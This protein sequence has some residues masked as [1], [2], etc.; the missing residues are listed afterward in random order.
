[1][2]NT[3]KLIEEILKG[4]QEYITDGYSMSIGEIVSNYKEGEIDINPDF[5]RKFRWTDH[6]RSRLIESILIGVPLPSIFVY[7]NDKGI[8][9]VVDGVQRLSTILEFMGELKDKDGNKIPQS[10]LVRTKMLPSIEGLK[11]SDFPKEPLQIDFRRTKIEVKIIK[12]N[13][14]PNAKFEVFQRLNYSSVLSGQEFRNAVLIMLN[15]ELYEWLKTLAENNDFQTCLDLTDRWKD[16][17]YDYE[18]VLRLFIFAL[19][20]NKPIYKVDDFINDNF[21]Y[22]DDDSLIQKIQD[23]QF[24]IDL[25]KKKFIKTFELLNQAKGAEV[26]KKGGRGTQFLESYFESI[27]IGLYSNIDEYIQDDIALLQS[28]IDDIDNHIPKALNTSSRI[29]KTVSFGKEYFKK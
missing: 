9:E 27:A 8:W 5:Q 10:T 6:Q 19:Y 28:K 26:F 20:A 21:I 14:H 4:R 23:E 17:Q 16:E 13:S 29:P 15:R 24:N 11:W 12:N 2:T 1:M 22:N 7:Q 18:L 25:E 3:E